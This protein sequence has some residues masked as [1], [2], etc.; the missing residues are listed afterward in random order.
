MA[1]AAK[2]IGLA[3]LHKKLQRMPEVAK[4]HIRAEMEKAA[5]EIV[6]MMRN[7]VPSPGNGKYATGTLR[8]SIG[9]TWGK[10]PRGTSV[11]ATATASMGGDLTITF[12]AGG[13]DAFHARFVEFGTKHMNAK[14]FFYVSW[15][16]NRKKARSRIRRAITK[17]A[18]EV[19]SS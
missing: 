11:I 14:P 17:A 3:K 8:D 7:L 15:R 18:K 4:N 19:A 5:E 9:W 1:S 13:G 12:Y 2:I 10:A 6:S 16:A